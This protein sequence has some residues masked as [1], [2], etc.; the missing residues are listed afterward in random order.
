MTQ[1]GAHFG[2]IEVISCNSGSDILRVKLG[3]A[4][5]DELAGASTVFSMAQQAMS[6]SITNGGSLVAIPAQ[7]ADPQLIN[8]PTGL[9]K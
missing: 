3:K 4:A 6:H 1:C 5:S 8:V 2:A 7:P 9:G